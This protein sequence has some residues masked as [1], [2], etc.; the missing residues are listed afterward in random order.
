[1]SAADDNYEVFLVTDGAEFLVLERASHVE[2]RITARNV[3]KWCGDTAYVRDAR[4]GEVE[5]V[6]V[7]L[8]FTA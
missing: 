3:S 1:M 5:A 2:A 4:T 8:L 7:T 6:N